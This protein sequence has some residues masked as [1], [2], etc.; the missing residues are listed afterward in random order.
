M[1]Y[2]KINISQLVE[3]DKCSAVL[4]VL[5]SK[6]G[7]HRGRSPVLPQTLAV[8]DGVSLHQ[9]AGPVV[10]DLEVESVG[11]DLPVQ[12]PG[13]HEEP[14]L[15]VSSEDNFVHVERE[16]SLAL[17]NHRRGEVVLLAV[18]WDQEGG[19]V[20]QQVGIVLEIIQEEIFADNGEVRVLHVC[21][22][23]QG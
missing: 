12:A 15:E 11:G 13:L 22:D 3:R 18:R 9:E 20:P 1:V 5:Y 10:G 2:A 19:E 17:V 14:V 4:P 23:L 6:T 16:A 8:E 7:H 21:T